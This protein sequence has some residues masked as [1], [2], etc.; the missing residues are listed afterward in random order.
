MIVN[1]L[2]QWSFQIADREIKGQVRTD[3]Q[4]NRGRQEPDPR[5]GQPSRRPERRHPRQ[6][7]LRAAKPLRPTAARR[8]EQLGARDLLRK[9]DDQRRTDR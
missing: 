8:E 2:F 6:A 1:Y 9:R 4:T 5:A 3:R 7:H